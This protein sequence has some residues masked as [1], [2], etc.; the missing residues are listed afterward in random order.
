MILAVKFADFG[1]GAVVGA[2]IT[3]AIWIFLDQRRRNDERKSRFLEEK[4]LM[5]RNVVQAFDAMA[6]QVILFGKF[7]PYFRRAEELD[8]EAQELAERAYQLLNKSLAENRRRYWDHGTD[9]SL[10]AS[11]APKRAATAALETMQQMLACIAA[12]EPCDLTVMQVVLEDELHNFRYFV[13][14]DLGIDA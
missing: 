11:K 7:D 6:E 10:L 9:F 1:F 14:Q 3:G 8:P 12:D 2:I 5:Y 13:R 4:R